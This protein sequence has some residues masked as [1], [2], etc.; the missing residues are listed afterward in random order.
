MNS[1]P[2]GSARHRQAL[3]ALRWL[4]RAQQLWNAKAE[5]QGISAHLAEYVRLRRLIFMADAAVGAGEVVTAEQYARDM[6]RI[7]EVARMAG[8]PAQSDPGRDDVYAAH[9]VL[10][11]VA[12]ARGD[13]EAAEAHL[14]EA[15]AESPTGFPL[16]RGGP[17]TELAQ[18]LLEAGR[19]E[20]VLTYLRS[21]RAFW[22][23]GRELLNEW[24]NQI[25]RGVT[26]D[27]ATRVY[28]SSTGRVKRWR[29]YP[30][31]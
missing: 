25:S 5:R 31:N 11:K 2:P 24:I 12:M 28:R 10:G 17:D 6:L 15:V 27:L 20:A 18:A 14:G 22:I 16:T 26:P 7:P 9:I 4:E 8:A 13:L 23:W 19:T 21:C 29:L 30:P 1:K 3:L